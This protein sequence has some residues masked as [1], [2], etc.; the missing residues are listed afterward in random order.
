MKKIVPEDAVLIPEQAK[1]VFKGQIFD[2]YQWQQAMFD[3]SSAT[4]EMLKRP[5]TVI[6]ICVVGDK[7]IVEDYNQPNV[8]SKLSLP[9]GRVDKTDDSPLAAVQ[10][11][12]E[13]E[14]GYHFKHWRLL[15]VVQAHTKLEWFTY[16]Y[17]AWDGDKLVEQKLDAGEKIQLKLILFD[18]FK[19]LVSGRAGFLG[20][21]EVVLKDVK[22]LDELLR[23][24]EFVGKTIER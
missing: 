5:D 7:I 9:A 21:T 3:G 22:S 12:V 14:T 24:P 10:R 20:N 4:F 15:H 1:R 2:V 19:K 8:G 23:L 13:E 11:E 16:F 6:A 17:L 18:E